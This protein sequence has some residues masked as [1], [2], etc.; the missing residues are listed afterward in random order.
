M[1]KYRFPIPSVRPRNLILEIKEGSFG[2]IPYISLGKE[3]LLP[4]GGWAFHSTPD[5]AYN[6]AMDYI[7]LLSTRFS[8]ISEIQGP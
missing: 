5:A 2:Y 7:F 3:E 6:D 4:E 8:K 1:Y